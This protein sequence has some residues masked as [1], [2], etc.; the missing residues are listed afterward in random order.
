MEGNK[1]IMTIVCDDVETAVEIEEK[2]ASVL[3]QA[4]QTILGSQANIEVKR[5]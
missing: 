2:M 3:K 4:M 5:E 1:I